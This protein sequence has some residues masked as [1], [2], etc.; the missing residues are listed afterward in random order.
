MKIEMWFFWKVWH[1][2]HKVCFKYQKTKNPIEFEW[3]LTF[4]DDATGTWD[5]EAWIFKGLKRPDKSS[6]SAEFIGK[7]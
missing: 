6:Q 4:T 5:F 7:N 1:T 3:I 2:F